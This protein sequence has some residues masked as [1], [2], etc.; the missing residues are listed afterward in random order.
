M[1]EGLGAISG[2]EFI[3]LTANR[4]CVLVLVTDVE[5]S[6]NLKAGCNRSDVTR[7][8]AVSCGGSK[9]RPNRD[10]ISL[11]ILTWSLLLPQLQ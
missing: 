10:K 3:D 9:K 7:L 2:L 5:S 6:L 8:F 4:Y 1:A 11:N